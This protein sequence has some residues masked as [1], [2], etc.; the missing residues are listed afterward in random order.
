MPVE[1]L[2]T[3]GAPARDAGARSMPADALYAVVLRPHR[4]MGPQ[5]FAR[6]I[7]LAYALFLVP[8]LGMLGT[9]ALWVTLPFVLLALGALWYF[10]R[11]NAAD[12]VLYERLTVWPRAIE[13]VRHEPRRPERGWRADPYWARLFLHPTGGPVRNYVTLRGGGREIELGVFLSPQERA[14]L[15][16][17][18]KGLL[19]RLRLPS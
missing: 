17:E 12:G 16:A 3:E 4:S 10:I 18:L 11:R 13:V 1:K 2:I 8:L 9:A 6:V 7:A 19:E 14:A 5:G 15:Y